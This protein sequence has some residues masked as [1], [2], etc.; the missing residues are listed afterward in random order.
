M[1]IAYI[2]LNEE[3]VMA[4]IADWSSVIQLLCAYT[5]LIK[6]Y[7]DY[8]DGTEKE[9]QALLSNARDQLNELLIL[10]GISH[11]AP[12]PEPDKFHWIVWKRTSLLELAGHLSFM[13]DWY[14]RR[15][16][17]IQAAD[18]KRNLLLVVIG[19]VAL[20]LLLV[21]AAAKDITVPPLL[22]IVVA[23]A[24]W[25]PVLY[26]MVKTWFEDRTLR[27]WISMSKKPK[28]IPDP[29]P[30]PFRGMYYAVTNHVRRIHS[31]KVGPLARAISLGVITPAPNK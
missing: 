24:L 13:T 23:L 31:D 17:A 26:I 8:K 20:C 30:V 15:S 22:G 1:R 25:S 12:K 18:K 3:F 21:S 6:G 7:V 29:S 11:D 10:E 2:D 28:N 16:K 19:V 9:A 5:L 14:Y 4:V 27:S